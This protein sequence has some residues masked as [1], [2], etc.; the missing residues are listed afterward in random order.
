MKSW[1]ITSVAVGQ[2]F[3]FKTRLPL[4]PHDAS[5]CLMFYKHFEWMFWTMLRV[6]TL[7]S[8]FL[9][10]GTLILRTKHW[11]CLLEAFLRTRTLVLRKKHWS[12]RRPQEIGRNIDKS[13]CWHPTLW[14]RSIQRVH[15]TLG[16]E[17]HHAGTEAVWSWNR[18]VCT[19]ITCG[20]SWPLLK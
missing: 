11:S 14:N 5:H 17:E 1:S 3:Y 19:C 7:F 2:Q 12:W 9:R 10:T 15:K 20:I 4:C 8:L 18:I 6:S 16:T 13:M